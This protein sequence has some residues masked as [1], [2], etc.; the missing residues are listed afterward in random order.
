MR[1]CASCGSPT[2]T[3]ESPILGKKIINP[4]QLL[5]VKRNTIPKQIGKKS[6][7]F[8]RSCSSNQSSQCHLGELLDICI[9]PELSKRK[10]N[11]EVPYDMKIKGFEQLVSMIKTLQPLDPLYKFY[12]Q[13]IFEA[14]MINIEH[15]IIENPVDLFFEYE[16]GGSAPNQ[17]E[18]QYQVLNVLFWLQFFMSD[19]EIFDIRFIKQLLNVSNTPCYK[20]RFAIKRIVVNCIEINKA[21]RQNVVS[22]LIKVLNDHSYL[23]PRPFSVSTSLSILNSI[24]E[25]DPRG[26]LFT[27]VQFYES[28]LPLITDPHYV[29]YQTEMAELLERY[30]SNLPQFSIPYLKH[31]VNYFP[32]LRIAKQVSFINSILSLITKIPETNISQI[33]P[34]VLFIFVQ[35]LTSYSSF[36]R[37]AAINLWRNPQCVNILKAYV[38]IINRIINEFDFITY[39][40]KQIEGYLA[41]VKETMKTYDTE[42]KPYIDINSINK[43]RQNKSV[44]NLFRKNY[45]DSIN[46]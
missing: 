26:E 17:Y 24:L 11:N 22:V 8:F 27:E 38:P 36:V 4:S 5:V 7:P 23:L 32:K 39:D 19:T 25:R 13:T 46:E 30:I 1:L 18:L 41:Y 37:D 2:A 44:W 3:R 21:F 16:Q 43:R 6:M 20:A 12:C 33:L 35:S 40:D 28:I 34:K 42:K 9:C 29:I 14:M 45:D 31:L 15:P 10:S